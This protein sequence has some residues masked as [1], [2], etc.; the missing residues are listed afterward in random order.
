MKSFL[1]FVI[2]TPIFY[3]HIS[4][5]LQIRTILQ[6]DHHISSSKYFCNMETCLWAR[7]ITTHGGTGSA[8]SHNGSNIFSKLIPLVHWN[9]EFGIMLWYIL[10]L[11]NISI[12]SK[13]ECMYVNTCVPHQIV[14]DHMNKENCSGYCICSYHRNFLLQTDKTSTKQCQNIYYLRSVSIHTYISLVTYLV[15]IIWYKCNPMSKF[16]SW[17]KISEPIGERANN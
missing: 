4:S 2:V 1:N 5:C 14:E 15:D 12:K 10:E 7:D 17:I 16:K 13:C 6:H 11:E 9:M 8:S 3:Y